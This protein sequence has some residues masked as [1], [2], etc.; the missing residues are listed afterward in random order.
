M[1]HDFAELKLNA[2]LGSAN[3]GAVPA[4]LDEDMEEHVN[5]YVK[6]CLDL[7]RETMGACAVE[8]RFVLDYIRPDVFGTN[9]FSC[10]DDCEVLHI[11]D[12]K[13]G[14][15][16]VNPAGNKQLMFYALGA[17]HANKLDPFDIFLHIYQP[18]A[19][20][21]KKYRVAQINLVELLEFEAQLREAI[22]RVDAEPEKRVPGSHCFFC[23]NQKCPEFMANAL[24]D[25]STEPEDTIVL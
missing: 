20:T 2:S 4:C 3:T 11:V 12:L 5:G 21:K 15:S 1:A 13:Y 9:D 24:K 18:R 19:S 7:H 23:N 6:Y 16:I 22:K 8:Q 14:K 25:I 17:I 10:W